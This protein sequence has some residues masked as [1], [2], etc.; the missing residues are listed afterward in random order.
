MHKVKRDPREI[1]LRFVCLLTSGL[2]DSRP[3][4]RQD[5]LRFDVSSFALWERGKIVNVIELARTWQ[6]RGEMPSD[7][8]LE[9][10]VST[11]SHFHSRS[12]QFVNYC[13]RKHREDNVSDKNARRLKN[14]PTEIPDPFTLLPGA[15]WK[16][17]DKP[18]GNEE[19]I[20][21]GRNGNP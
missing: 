14:I 20:R 16:R 7:L 10:I 11:Q 1:M 3:T 2:R 8:S 4:D 19:N 15:R 18:F 6:Q 13:Q 9:A 5:F 17:T 21:H 12:D